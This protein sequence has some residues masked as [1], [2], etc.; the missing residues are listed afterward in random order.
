M[1]SG[2]FV[3]FVLWV[4]GVSIY[5]DLVQPKGTALIRNSTESAEKLLTNPLSGD[6]RRLHELA[7]LSAAA[8]GV[9]NYNNLVGESD[10]LAD[11]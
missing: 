10:D 9:K 1:K 11:E 8:Y 6:F 4:V 3:V 7:F 2:L 5:P